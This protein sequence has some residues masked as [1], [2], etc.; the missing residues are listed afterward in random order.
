MKWIDFF[1]F[2][3]ITNPETM[4]KKSNRA[5]RNK[6]KRRRRNGGIMP[7]GVIGF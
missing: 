4:P 5:N 6:S 2:A 7:I 3:Y 1:L